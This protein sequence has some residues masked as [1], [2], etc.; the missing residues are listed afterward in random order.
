MRKR[1]LAIV[2]IA[3]VSIGLFAGCGSNKENATPSE[4]TQS[5]YIAVETSKAK[6]D[7]IFNA[8]VISGKISANKEVMIVPKMP[9]KVESI[10]VKVGDKVKAGTTLFTL[11]KVDTEVKVKQAK[12]GVNSASATIEQA[13]VGKDN[14]KVS[15]DT[16]L[17]GLEQAQVAID[18]AKV[19]L[20]AA[21]ASYTVAKANYDLNYEK[22]QNA[23]MNFERTKELYE[24]GI[25]SKSQYEQAELAAS[26]KSLEL[27]KAQ[28]NQAK[29][30]LKQAENGC[31][32]AEVA[33]KKA[34]AGITQTENGSKQAD[35]AYKQAQ[36]GY[37]N[38]QAVY[39]QAVQ[40]MNDLTVTSPI[41][42]IVSSVNVEE[43]E[44]A[45]NAQSAVTIVDMDKVYL[46]VNVTEN[47]INKVQ[48][49]IKVKVNI[50]SAGKNEFEGEIY[51]ISPA[52]DPRT[53]LYS[54]EIEI[55][56]KDHIIKPGMFAN[57]EFDTDIRNDV[58]VVKSEAITI[59]D[60]KQIV[61]IEKNGKVEMREVETGLDNGT[62]IE[63]ING[64]KD[65]EEIVVKGQNYLQNNSVVKVVNSSKEGNKKENSDKKIENNSNNS[66]EDLK[67]ESDRGDN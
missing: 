12:S 13:Q 15:Q 35:A 4:T 14:A 55:D 25:V 59:E 61:Y 30:V 27:L 11:E 44:M 20:E 36:A 45:S 1:I 63:V 60:G 29:V 28:L 67:K 66:E 19:G 54:I 17:A 10:E 43:G 53:Q 26:D 62:Y 51:T 6:R 58:V 52:A 34:Q 38:A 64:I 42:G 46:N 47:L 23:K 2:L 8:A 33:Y 5:N 16:A 22:I 32:Q 39:S 41:K 21:Q 48:K 31:K 3:V 56:N 18:N 40:L 7:K 50:P 24:Q 49:G 65:G 37:S 9:G 57:V